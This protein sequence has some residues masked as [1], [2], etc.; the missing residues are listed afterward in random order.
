[1]RSEDFAK[2]FGQGLIS[3]LVSPAFRREAAG[4]GGYDTSHMG[5]L[6]GEV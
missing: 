2:D 1:M 6:V 3:L 4:L 5:E